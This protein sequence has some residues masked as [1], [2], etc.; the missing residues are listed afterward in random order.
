MPHRKAVSVLPDPV[1]ARISVCRPAAMAGQPCSWAVVGAGND[2]LN[3]VRTGSEK[4]SSEPI[5]EAYG[6]GVAAGSGPSAASGTWSG[7][8]A[9]PSQKKKISAGTR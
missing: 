6:A 4:R 9:R 3:Q 5:R 8:V 2:E 7:E 1:G